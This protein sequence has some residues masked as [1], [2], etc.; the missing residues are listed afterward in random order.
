MPCVWLG[1]SD[2]FFANGCVGMLKGSLRDGRWCEVLVLYKSDE[3]GKRS[4]MGRRSDMMDLRSDLRLRAVFREMLCCDLYG[5][6][7]TCC[8]FV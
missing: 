7:S 5:Y 4:D 2:F 6:L 8:I 1:I 3:S